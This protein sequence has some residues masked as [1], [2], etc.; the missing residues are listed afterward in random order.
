MRVKIVLD[1][2]NLFEIAAPDEQRNLVSEAVE[3]LADRIA[4][5]HAKDRTAAGAFATC[6][7]GVIDFPHFLGS[8]QSAGF[9]GPVVTHGLTPAEAPEV[10]EFLRS[11]LAQSPAD[12]VGTP[13]A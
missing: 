5:A 7:K 12:D 3:L 4:M 8:L 9:D 2:A 1:P 6:G 10:A 11:V 13:G